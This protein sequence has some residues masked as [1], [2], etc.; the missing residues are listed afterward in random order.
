MLGHRISSFEE[1]RKKNND[2]V[3]ESELSKI[4]IFKIANKDTIYLPLEKYNKIDKLEVS[5]DFGYSII[6]YYL[7]ITDKM[8]EK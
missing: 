5:N 7:T 4:V 3:V 2:I 8:F 1:Y 6:Y